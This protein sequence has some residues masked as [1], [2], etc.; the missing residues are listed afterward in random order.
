MVLV[1]L[2]EVDPVVVGVKKLLANWVE[3][4]FAVAQFP[5]ARGCGC[6]LGSEKTA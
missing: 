3:G 2:V 1:H 4:D 5:V 6:N